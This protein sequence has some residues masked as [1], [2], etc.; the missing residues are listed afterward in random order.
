MGGTL[1]EPANIAARRF[2]ASEPR[3]LGERSPA[4]GPALLAARGLDGGLAG[5]LALLQAPLHQRDDQDEEREERDQDEPGVRDLLVVDLAEGALARVLGQRDRRE[6]GQQREGEQQGRDQTAHRQGIV[7]N[8]APWRHSRASGST[9]AS[10]SCGWTG[11][12]SATR[13]TRRCWR[14]S[15]PRSRSWPPTP[16]CGCWSS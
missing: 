2:F 1:R 15:P 7:L 6:E 11:P 5:V 12:R 4:A 13:W 16:S 14:S 3:P 9:T 10:R 8:A